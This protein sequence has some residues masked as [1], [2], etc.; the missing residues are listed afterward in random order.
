MTAVLNW[1][2]VPQSVSEKKLMGC[3]EK[4][5][6]FFCY[7]YILARGWSS[8]LILKTNDLATFKSAAIFKSVLFQA[9]AMK[10]K[11]FFISCTS[12][13]FHG[14]DEKKNDKIFKVSYYRYSQMPDAF[15]TFNTFKKWTWSD[16]T[17]PPHNAQGK[18]NFQGR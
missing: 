2:H 9:K 7:N 1:L 14:E 5:K 17:P 18:S 11:Y 16:A 4:F 13:S 6:A 8:F 15:C 12:W 10:T 3:K